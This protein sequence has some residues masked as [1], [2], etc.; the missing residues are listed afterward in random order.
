MT[1][2]LDTPD[3]RPP[4]LT[5]VALLAL[6]LA[7]GVAGY[8]D[9]PAEMVV[10]WHVH[11]D[12]GTRLTTA[13]RPVATFGIPVAAAGA[14]AAVETASARLGV[15]E[16]LDDLRFVYDAVVHLVLIG[17]CAAQ[18]VIVAANL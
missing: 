2:S 4:R 15:R 17:L 16:R 10:G 6:A 3:V 13:P 18:V 5:A 14:Y 8:A 11:L 7:V 1:T 12:G 9:L